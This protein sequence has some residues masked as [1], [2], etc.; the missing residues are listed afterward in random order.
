MGNGCRYLIR[1]EVRPGMY[2]AADACLVSLSQLALHA[3][4]TFTSTSTNRQRALSAMRAQ[5]Q[6]LSTNQL[7]AD[8]PSPSC[9][10]PKSS[11]QRTTEPLLIN[12]T[13]ARSKLRHRLRVHLHTLVAAHTPSAGRLLAQP[14]CAQP[15]GAAHQLSWIT[16]S[17]AHPAASCRAGATGPR[18]WSRARARL[19]MPRIHKCQFPQRHV[20]H[21]VQAPTTLNQGL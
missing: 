9:F 10:N 4:T 20:Q 19:R 15:L 16:N 1:D 3:D 17:Q 18:A 21:T 2:R 13:L 14:E 8:V 12:K 6:L 7:S 5:A 11:C